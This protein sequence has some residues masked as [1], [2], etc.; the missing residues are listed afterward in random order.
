MLASVRTFA[1]SAALDAS[2]SSCDASLFNASR[3]A[4]PNAFSA[5]AS[6]LRIE[7]T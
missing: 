5:L 1:A 7:D 2:L 6:E 4:E 3:R